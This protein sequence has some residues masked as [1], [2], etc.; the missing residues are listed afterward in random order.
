MACL[1]TEAGRGAPC[2]HGHKFKFN[3]P[4]T[5]PAASEVL[6]V[7]DAQF[8]RVRVSR[9]SRFHWRNCAHREIEIVRIEV[10]EP[11]GPKGNLHL[12]ELATPSVKKRVS[13]RQKSKKSA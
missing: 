12:L 2:K 10:I 11:V 5:H 8:G 9:W 1:L 3:D 13:K 4:Q 6:E 7:E